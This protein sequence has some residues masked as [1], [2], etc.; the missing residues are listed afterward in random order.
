MSIDSL[1]W[2]CRIFLFLDPDSLLT[3]LVP[4]SDR[5]AAG[6]SAVFVG[7]FAY[8]AQRW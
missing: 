7:L 8:W 4:D 2:S 6:R 3:V 1:S 5:F